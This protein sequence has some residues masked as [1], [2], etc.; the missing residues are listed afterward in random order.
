MALSSALPWAE[1]LRPYRRRVRLLLAWRYGAIGGVAGALV[2]T[3]LSLLDWLALVVIYPWQLGACAAAG[4]LIG[5]F[6]AL[7]VRVSDMAVAQLIDHRAGLKDRLQTALERSNGA[8]LFD[9]PLAEDAYLALQA[10]RPAQVL[11]LRFG[12]WQQAFVGALALL[13]FVQ[14]LPQIL[15]VVVPERRE[16]QKEIKQVAEQ[17]QEVAKP[18]LEEAKKPDADELTKRIAQQVRL[19]NKRAHEAKMSKREALL[20]YNAILEQARQLEQRTQRQLEQLNE[21]T[22]TTAAQLEKLAR[23]SL[24]EPDSQL[25][26]HLERIARAEKSLQKELQRLRRQ[27]LSG[28][29]ERGNPLSEA[30]R[31][32]L[33]QQI[34]QLQATLNA[35]QATALYREMAALQHQLNSGKDLQ[36]RPLSP[37]QRAAL[38]EQLK[39]LLRALQ[40]AKPTDLGQQIEALQRQIQAIQEQL[41]SGKDAQGNPLS[42]EQIEQLQRQLQ[43]LQ[44]QL[45]ALQLSQ[46][47][48]EFLRKLREALRNDPAFKE[49]M[50]HLRKLAEQMQRLRQQ[51]DPQLRKLTQEEIE[52]RLRALEKHIEELAKRYK[53]DEQIRELARQILEQIKQMRQLCQCQGACLRLGL[54]SSFDELAGI[55]AGFGPAWEHNEYF[56][57]PET[58]NQG[59]K[60]PELKIPMKDTPVSGQPPLGPTTGD[61]I[62]FKAPPVPSGS[63]VPLSQALPTYQKKAEQALNQQ[64][65]PPAE[66]KRVKRY[67]DSLRSGN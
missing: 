42:P 25:A 67:F 64:N 17:I 36:G 23:L 16:E 51:Q 8:H 66:R 61:Y 15:A 2:A 48:R 3:A 63:S 33:R 31:A 57:Q 13:L 21:R 50:E 41:R 29:D 59:E 43:S 58:F 7:L 56:G 52:Q 65:I 19:Y 30:Q 46:E 12:R 27:L 26:Q 37:Q 32:A 20:R 53:T 40:D 6:Y 10:V 44:E 62:E 5:V 47:A 34:Q 11:R 9:A 35:L 28:N 54:S 60:Q 45:R 49:A 14:L 38:E 18:I 4:V 22:Q 39:R 55:G 24:P 1:R